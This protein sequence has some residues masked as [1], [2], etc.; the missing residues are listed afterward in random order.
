MEEKEYAS[1]LLLQDLIAEHPDL[2]AG[3]Q[4]DEENPKRWLLIKKEQEMYSEEE[5]S[6]LF[7]WIISSLTRTAYQPLWRLK[8]AATPV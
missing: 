7:T 5:G 2:L 4:M 1:E 8:E 6:M 3:D